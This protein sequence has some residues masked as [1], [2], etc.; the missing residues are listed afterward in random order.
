[1]VEMIIRYYLFCLSFFF[2][3]NNGL[4]LLLCFVV[5][6]LSTCSA[7][8]NSQLS[9]SVQPE[10]QLDQPKTSLAGHVDQTHLPS[11]LNK[12]PNPYL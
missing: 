4:H 2:F 11:V 5:M 8:N 7:Q 1:M 6:N 12:Q 10:W 3:L 9:D